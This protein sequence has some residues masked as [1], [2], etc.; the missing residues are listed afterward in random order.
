MRSW[1]RCWP[2]TPRRAPSSA[3]TSPGS[4]SPRGVHGLIDTIRANIDGLSGFKKDIALFA[5]GK[6]CMS[7]KGGFGHFSSTTPYGKREDTPTESRSASPRTSRVST[8]CLRQR[9]RLQ[10]QPQRRQRVPEERQGGPGLFD[11]PYA[12]EFSTTNYEKAYHFVE[13]LMTYWDGLRLVEGSKTRHYE[14]DHKSVT[15]A[16][17]KAFFETFLGNARH[18]PHWLISYR[19]RALSQRAG[20]EGADRG[21]RFLAGDAVPRPPLR[22]HLAP[23]RGVARQG[24]A[25]H[26]PVGQGP[27]G[28]GWRLRRT[29]CRGGLGGDGERGP[30]PGA[31]SEGVR[32]GQ[33]PAQ[34]ARRHRR[35]LHSHRPAQA[36]VRAGRA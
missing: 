2:P 24:A 35:R 15:A 5:L 1:R 14:T 11:P 31:R 36:A 7:G 20:D 25:L 19:D 17:A 27:V 32:A 26:L 10:G 21:A 13:G 23:R 8:P 12:T 3:T 28:R 4:S 29:A 9:R 22:H 33:L 16:T 18:I 30:L 34:G 6:T